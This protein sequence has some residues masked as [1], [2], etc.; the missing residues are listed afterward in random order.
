MINND[1]P[2][3]GDAR[4]EVSFSEAFKFWLKLGFISFGGP[5]GQIANMH[6]ELVDRRRWISEKRFLHALNY[7]MVLPG[8]EAQQLATYI[9]WLLHGSRGGI[10]AGALFVIPSL[11]IL[12]LLSAIYVAFGQVPVVAAVIDGIKP[13]VVAIVIGAVL[14]I[15]GRAIKNRIL[16]CFAIASFLALAVF[17]LPFPLIV[18][19]AGVLG[20][21]GAHIAPDKFKAGGHTAKAKKAATDSVL[22]SDLPFVID[23]EHEPPPHTRP[24]WIRF[25]LQF[26]IGAV[27]WC[28]PI[29]LLV[30]WQDWDGTFTRMGT[31]FTTAALV[32]FGGAYAVLPFVAQQAV[33]TYQWLKP[34]QMIDGLA[35]GETTPGPLI[36][37]V[38]FV[39]FVGGWQASGLGWTGAILGSV[40]ATYFTFL[41]S[42]LFILM[43][44]PFIEHMRGELRLTGALTGIT[45]AVVGVILNLALFFG[46]TV[47]FPGLASESVWDLPYVGDLWSTSNPFAMVLCLLAFVS[48]SRWQVSLPIVVA[49][50]GVC[51]LV[52]HLFFG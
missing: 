49:A 25:A 1:L 39:G 36:M 2:A 29:A 16:L 33:S 10:V 31:F 32:T 50:C 41:P 22:A 6:T 26:A 30:A 42:F 8:P 35:L 27:L 23:D 15:G 9:G 48:L 13:A 5:A 17:Q 28:A 18:V 11:F 21:I 20:W 14:R 12:M 44:A 46:K 52:K 34:G 3:S 38:A 37:V 51:G 40:I 43:G 7:C 19:T 4:R 45:A 47:F 24:N